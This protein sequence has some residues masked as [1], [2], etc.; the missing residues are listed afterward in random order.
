LI[1]GKFTLANNQ[2]QLS[3]ARTAM[4]SDRAGQHSLAAS[5]NSLSFN[6]SSLEDIADELLEPYVVT[7][8]SH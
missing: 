4:S 7:S 5:L 6:V 8:E 3:R 2:Q 1:C